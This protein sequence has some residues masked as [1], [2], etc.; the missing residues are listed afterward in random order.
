MAFQPNQQIYHRLENPGTQTKALAQIQKSSGRI[1]GRIPRFGYTPCVKAYFGPLPDG[2]H[3][4]EF[5]TDVPHDQRHSN[6]IQARWYYPI[7]PGVGL[8]RINDEEFAWI[9]ATV[10]RII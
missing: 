5:V 6:P 3:G 1:L 10:T 7:T 9:P 4:I 2:S 8:V